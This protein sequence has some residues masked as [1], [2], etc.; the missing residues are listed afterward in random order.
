MRFWKRAQPEASTRPPRNRAEAFAVYAPF[1]LE[2]LARLAALKDR[3]ALAPCQRRLVDQALYATY[4]DCV[5]V[6]ARDEAIELLGAEH[7]GD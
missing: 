4:W 7:G 2:R 5:R 6:G 1:F 3:P